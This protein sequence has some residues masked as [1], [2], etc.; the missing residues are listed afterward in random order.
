MGMGQYMGKLHAKLNVPAATLCKGLCSDSQFRNYEAGQR[1]LDVFVENRLFER[2]GCSTDTMQF[3]MKLETYSCWKDRMEILYEIMRNH[4][5]KARES[6]REFEENYRT[7]PLQLQYVLRMRSFIAILEGEKNSIIADLIEKALRCTVPNYE[8]GTYRFLFLAPQEVDM[9]LDWLYYSNEQ[10]DEALWDVVMYIQNGCFDTVQKGY[11][12][13]KAVI[14]Y[15]NAVE[16]SN[17]IEQWSDEFLIKVYKLVTEALECVTEKKCLSGMKEILSLRTKILR[18]LQHV[19]TGYSEQLFENEKWERSILQLF[20][21]IEVTNI[22]E[23]NYRLYMIRNVNCICDVLADC[24]AR[25]NIGNAQMA[26]AIDV[27]IRTIRNITKRSGRRHNPQVETARKMLSHMKLPHV[28]IRQ[29]FWIQSPEEKRLMNE[30]INSEIHGSEEVSL[31]ILR[32]LEERFDADMWYNL[33]EVRW[34]RLWLMYYR[35]ELSQTEYLAE[36]RSIIEECFSLQHIYENGVN[37]LS[38]A[39]IQYL[40]SYMQGLDLECEEMM[41]LIKVFEDFCN[42]KIETFQE[43]NYYPALHLLMKNVQSFYK[44]KGDYKKAIEICKMM[45]ELAKQTQD[46]YGVEAF[47]VAKWECEFMET[48]TADIEMLSWLEAV[49]EM[50]RDY[51]GMSRIQKDVEKFKNIN[52]ECPQAE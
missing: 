25:M 16:N 33:R 24:M 34:H 37:Y 14:R 2:A 40:S 41:R 32:E 21:Y 35:K 7:E 30:L 46:I 1:E 29:A 27:D 10:N 17:P 12:Y 31:K 36:V 26:E 4:F 19:V 8:D 28:Y 23:I 48:R 3:M 20:S 49:A 39:E 43:M 9:L 5:D 45:M 44:R 15:C 42:E 47:L 50:I 11:I 52:H 13:P 6:L 51:K 22:L 38:Y 18:R